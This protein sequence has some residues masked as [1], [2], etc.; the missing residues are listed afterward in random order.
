LNNPPYVQIITSTLGLILTIL[1]I[2]AYCMIELTL[3]YLL[4]SPIQSHLN[5]LKESLVMSP[6]HSAKTTQIARPEGE[7]SKDS[8]S[9]R[10]VN[11][12]VRLDN[13]RV[14]KLE[15]IFKLAVIAC[16][17]SV[18]LTALEN[19][20][21]CL[22]FYVYPGVK[23]WLAVYN[24]ASY[25]EMVI[26]SLTPILNY[27]RFRQMWRMKG[28]FER[29]KQS[30]QVAVSKSVNPAGKEAGYSTES[31]ESTQKMRTPRIKKKATLLQIQD[32][33]Q[34]GIDG[35]PSD[36]LG[37]LPSPVAQERDEIGTPSIIQEE[38]RR[39]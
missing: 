11:A 6:M 8:V 23:L 30:S 31:I 7:D 1:F 18:F 33:T 34:I 27:F 3:L 5:D 19:V 25:L 28:L 21:Y 17:I 12:T 20:C 16:A 36:P 39:A 2:I 29:E 24:W 26:C 38:P 13:V 14:Q 15:E 10:A 37:A 4:L 22:A 35:N 9:S 32:D